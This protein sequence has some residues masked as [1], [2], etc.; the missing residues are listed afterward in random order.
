MKKTLLLLLSMFVTTSSLVAGCSNGS[1]SIRRAQPARITRAVIVRRAVPVRVVRA[2]CVQVRRACNQRMQC[3]RNN[4]QRCVQT[5]RV[6][7]GCQRSC[8]R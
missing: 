6:S 2:A 4:Q 7:R 5:A 1:C 3:G 8:R